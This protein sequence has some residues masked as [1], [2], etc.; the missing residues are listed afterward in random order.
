MDG[1]KFCDDLKT[2]ELARN[3]DYIRKEVKAG[4]NFCRSEQVKTVIVFDQSVL[5]S[6]NHYFKIY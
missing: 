6:R 5:G 3:D 4:F 2:M 1:S